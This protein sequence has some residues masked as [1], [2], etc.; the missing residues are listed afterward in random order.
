MKLYVIFGI[1]IA[2]AL[3]EVTRAEDGA[4]FGPDGHYI[5]SKNKHFS[6]S[7]YNKIGLIPFKRR[8]LPSI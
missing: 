8:H 1:I 2:T 7:K 3:I 4:I 6:H 5:K